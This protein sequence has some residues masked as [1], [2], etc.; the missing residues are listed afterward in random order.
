MGG[1]KG[2]VHTPILRHVLDAHGMGAS[3]LYRYDPCERRV[4]SRSIFIDHRVRHVN[5]PNA[6]EILLMIHIQSVNNYRYTAPVLMP[7]LY[8]KL[9]QERVNWI[10]IT[11]NLPRRPPSTSHNPEPSS[12]LLR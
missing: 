9:Y 12:L 8:H 7:R 11:P 1:N 2:R 4:T 10:R 6:T 5:I 3:R